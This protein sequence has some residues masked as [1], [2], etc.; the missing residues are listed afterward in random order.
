MLR[1]LLRECV[2]ANPLYVI[3]A[4]LL[5]YGVLK[6]TTEIDPQV[7]KARGI[8]LGLGLLHAYELC[9]LAVATIVLHHRA[10]QIKNASDG[11]GRDCHGLTIVAGVFLAGSF[12]ALDEPVAHWPAWGPFA[13]FAALLLALG[14]L[15][16]YARLPG[17][18]L[19]PFY[20]YLALVLIAGPAM[21]PLLGSPGVRLAIGAPAAQ[22]A[23]WLLGWMVLI[24]LFVLAATEARKAPGPKPR[25]EPDPLSTRVCGAWLIGICV[26][27]GLVHL[28]A[29]DWVFDRPYDPARF[30]P[31]A[32]MLLAV[33]LVFAWRTKQTSNDCFWMA[34]CAPAGVLQWLWFAR[35]PWSGADTLEALVSPAAQMAAACAV[36]YLGLSWATHARR[37]LWGLAGS[38][39]A[40]GATGLW[41]VR[42]LI[43]HFRALCFS[44]LGFLTL[45]GAMLVS[46]YREY[47]LRILEPVPTPV[48]QDSWDAF[49]SVV[50][51]GPKPP[52]A[53]D[54]PPPAL[55]E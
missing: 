11:I 55:G 28:V 9:L 39:T 35:S 17:V 50:D 15:E 22:G 25:I 41:H 29:R 8:L 32:A 16:W 31:S 51:A 24:P 46:I 44:G 37:F 1:W 30:L 12:L 18:K 20:R 48:P 10:N 13:V 4:A 33:A 19:P 34:C 52:D 2:R 27:A 7:G 36:F 40:P 53:S 47:L 49:G 14:K 43:P 23:A 3:S 38:V 42:D 54:P 5:S 26:I 6:L 21:G 45:L